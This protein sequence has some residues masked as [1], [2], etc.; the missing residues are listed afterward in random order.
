MRA[1]SQRRV[2]W[3]LNVL[4]GAGLVALIAW[5]VL[6]NRPECVQTDIQLDSSDTGTCI[7]GVL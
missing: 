7:L 5:I 4:L 3:F 2:I 1:H 6:G